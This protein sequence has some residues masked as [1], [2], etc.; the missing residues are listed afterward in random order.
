LEPSYGV[1][2]FVET[3]KKLY[4][5]FLKLPSEYESQPEIKIVNKKLNGKEVLLTE[6]FSYLERYS[7][8]KAFPKLRNNFILNTR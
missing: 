3:N 8:E 5:S 1:S 6:L 7:L 4:N 2:H